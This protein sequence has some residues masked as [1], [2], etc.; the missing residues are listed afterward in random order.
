MGV[1]LPFNKKENESIFRLELE[2]IKD[3]ILECI[4]KDKDLIAIGDFNVDFKAKPSKHSKLLTNLITSTNMFPFDM[5]Y[6]PENVITYHKDNDKTHNDHVICNETNSNLIDI[7]LFTDTS[8]NRSD[9]YGIVVT[10]KIKIDPNYIEPSHGI[11]LQRHYWNMQYFINNYKNTLSSTLN[12]IYPEFVKLGNKNMV[13]DSRT[14]RLHDLFMILH[15]DI[16]EAA[17][18]VGDHINEKIKVGNIKI[19]PWFN[20]KILEMQKEANQ[21][22]NNYLVTKDSHFDARSRGINKTIQKLIRDSE[23]KY[24]RNE[25]HDLEKIRHHDSKKFWSILDGKINTRAQCETDL[26]ETRNEFCNTFNKK[27]VHSNDLREKEETIKFL[28]DTENLVY[29][30]VI[31]KWEIEMIV[32]DL[33]NNKSIGIQEVSN[34]MIKNSPNK[35]VDILLVIIQLLINFGCIFENFNVSIIKPIIKDVNKALDS[36]G[37]IRPISVSN[38]FHTIMEKWILSKILETY[39]HTPKQFGFRRGYSCQHAIIMVL[40]TI[41]FCKRKKKRLF[42][43]LIDASKAF[44]KINRYK[45][46][47]ILMQI[48]R[49]AVLRYLIKYY[50]S[51]Q[52]LVRINKID[53]DIFKTELSV[54]QGGCLS[55]LLFAIY[56]A[57]L[58]EIIDNL[59]I[60]VTISNQKVNLIMYADDIA[61]MC[62]SKSDMD[63]LL[64]ALDQY[65]KNKEIKFNGNKTFLM[66]FNK[67][68]KKLNKK[69]LE[70]EK[71]ILKLDNE[72]IAEVNE[73][74]YLG[75][76]LSTTK[77]N[78]Y[79]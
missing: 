47:V 68:I 2:V 30:E 43:C 59:D 22:H 51:S 33:E 31:E 63:K 36:V 58:S 55:P 67:K 54:K 21:L 60:G 8:V 24:K 25:L 65:G 3:I 79:L 1:Y 17:D 38:V 75:F 42:L 34:E 5:I 64:K 74:R 50:T 32:N 9:H 77:L 4:A 26:T 44:D 39:R 61:L 41:K 16:K 53:S 7:F 57:D 37:N 40:E 28:H 10:T 48:C 23:S 70:E 13:N 52:A 12:M 62:E 19:K 78:K 71:I 49:P 20:D 46:W 27:L 73:A 56:V 6:W 11:T 72:S 76:I 15:H 35:L 66:V 69:E 29:D 14:K 45:L 18:Y